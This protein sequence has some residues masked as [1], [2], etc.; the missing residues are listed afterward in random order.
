[1]REVQRLGLPMFQIR[2][3]VDPGAPPSGLVEIND[4]TGVNRGTLAPLLDVTYF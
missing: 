2:I 4:S 1:M 3:L